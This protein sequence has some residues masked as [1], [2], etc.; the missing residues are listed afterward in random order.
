LEEGKQFFE[1]GEYGRAL[2]S[3]AQALA[4]DDQFAVA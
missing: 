2:D 4:I 1:A 3:I